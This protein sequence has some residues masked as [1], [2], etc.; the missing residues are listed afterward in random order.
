MTPVDEVI[1]TTVRTMAENHDLKKSVSNVLDVETNP[2]KAFMLWF[3]SE[4]LAIPDPRWNAFKQEA[5]WLLEQYELYQ[6]P[7]MPPPAM[8]PGE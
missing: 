1:M 6:P 5:I 2:K 7:P 8:V 3:S 4:A